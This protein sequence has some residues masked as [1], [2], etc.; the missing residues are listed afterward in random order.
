MGWSGAAG[1]GGECGGVGGRNAELGGTTE[2]P[3]PGN[4]IWSSLSS[5]YK[6]YV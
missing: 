3:G 2:V 6:Y 5:S 4:R 1:G